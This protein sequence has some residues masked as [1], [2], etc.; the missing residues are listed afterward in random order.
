M[1]RFLM[2]AILALGAATASAT[3]E[4]E[5]PAKKIMEEKQ[6]GQ[7]EPTLGDMNCAR[8]VK[9]RENYSDSYFTTL[10]WLIRNLDEAVPGWSEQTSPDNMAR[11]IDGYC[12]E[13]PHTL[14][15]TATE[16]FTGTLN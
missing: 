9:H 3:F 1:F 13:N 5:D 7:N 6:E 2:I 15:R 11:W 10:K 16:K 4:L 14:L 12:R 8:F